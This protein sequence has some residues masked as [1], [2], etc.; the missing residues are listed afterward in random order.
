MLGRQNTGIVPTA[1]RVAVDQVSK[2]ENPSPRVLQINTPLMERNT[3]L[4]ER[5]VVLLILHL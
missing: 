3:P 5:G 2:A 1:V 4:T